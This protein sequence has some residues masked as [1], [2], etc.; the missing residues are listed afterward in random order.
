MPDIVF[1]EIKKELPDIFEFIAPGSKSV[2]N[3][4]LICSALNKSVNRVSNFLLAEDTL[5]MINALSKLGIKYRYYHD[6]KTLE[7]TNF[8]PERNAE[9]YLGYAGTAYRFLL[10]MLLFLRGRFVFYGESELHKR[11][12]T[13][14]INS[15]NTMIDGEIIQR[16]DRIEANS[17]GLKNI[18]SIDIDARK[19]SQFLTALLLVA[20]VIFDKFKITSSSE[21]ISKTYI[22]LTIDMLNS[23]GISVINDNYRQF[24]FESK[25]QYNFSNYNVEGDYSAASYFAGIAMLTGRKTIIKNLN[26]F[27]VQGDKELLH[28]F[29]RM[30]ASVHYN[31]YEKSVAIIPN[32]ATLSGAGIVD[33]SKMQDVVPTLAVVAAFTQGKTIITNIGNLK[34]KEC[35]RYA[36]LH[37]ELK[38]CGVN[39]TAENDSLIIVGADSSS[40]NFAE[41]ETYKD[42]RM[43]MAFSLMALKIPGI[44]IKSAE[45]AS[46]TFPGFFEQFLKL[47]GKDMNAGNYYSEIYKSAYNE[48]S[49]KTEM[50]K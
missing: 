26:K 30:G 40:Y 38:K 46:K 7:K 36:A 11:P 48:F 25:Q 1:S 3:R 15:L 12:I 6:R 35:D 2:T 23:T 32:K 19:S 47:F 4:I 45:C 10:A 29:E 39:I 9:I 43:A 13:E 42:H 41:I 14:L 50:I 16:Q 28:I 27:S 31:D 49:E 20:P 8:L 37:T 24:I 17:S 21:I 33:M 34:F 18:D 44:V 5:I 22:D